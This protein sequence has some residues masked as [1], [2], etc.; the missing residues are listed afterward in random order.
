MRYLVTDPRQAI[1]YHGKPLSGWLRPELPVVFGSESARWVSDDV[2]EK[3]RYR[4]NCPG[5]HWGEAVAALPD[6]CH[7]GVLMPRARRAHQPRA[8][9]KIMNEPVTHRKIPKPRITME[10][11]STKARSNAPPHASTIAPLISR[12]LRP[13]WSMLHASFISLAG[14]PNCRQ[15]P[16]PV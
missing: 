10:P 3:D 11:V 5:S 13:R 16:P 15:T 1:E 7:I 4:G 2:R 14:W 12:A 6:P 9:S 8:P